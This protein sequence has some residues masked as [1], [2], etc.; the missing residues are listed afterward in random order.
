MSKKNI[1]YFVYIYFLYGAYFIEIKYINIICRFFYIT[2]KHVFYKVFMHQCC[3][4][5]N[6]TM[7]RTMMLS[8]T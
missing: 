5:M 4:T 6:R 8:I 3:D 7:D 2:L 1:A